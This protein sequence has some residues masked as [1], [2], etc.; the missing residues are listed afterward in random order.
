LT[1]RK[2]FIYAIEA[3]SKISQKYNTIRMIIAGGDGNATEELK[4]YVEQLNL[5]KRITFFG[6]Y[7]HNSLLKLQQSSN[8][9]LFPS[10]NEGMSNSMLEAMAS[11][12]P[13]I[14]TPTGG[15]QELVEEGKN[16]FLVGFRDAEDIAKKLEMLIQDKDLCKEMGRESRR[17]AQ[18]LS[19]SSVALEYKNRY[20]QSI[21]KNEK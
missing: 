18:T 17:R 13:V 9:F 20:A 6:E 7:N 21:S 16:G 2:G 15:A 1:R 19:W 10:L 12:L 5:T 3:F 14:M 8:I 11:G 4:R